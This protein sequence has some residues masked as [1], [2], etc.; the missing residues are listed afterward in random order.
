M[1]NSTQNGAPVPVKP[2]DSTLSAI[3]TLLDQLTAD[4]KA[5]FHAY[6]LAVK[7]NDQDAITTTKQAIDD[8]LAPPEPASPTYTLTLNH[9]QY[10]QL[11][12]MVNHSFQTIALVKLLHAGVMEFENA[13]S[14]NTTPCIGDL[15]FGLGDLL[16]KVE[17]LSLFVDELSVSFDTTQ[18]DTM[19]RGGTAQ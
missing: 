14:L 11:D 7:A 10:T 2:A 1:D 15:V 13:P 17:Q 8:F 4:D 18:A 12:A 19:S 5:L 16:G 3:K 6:L 9:A